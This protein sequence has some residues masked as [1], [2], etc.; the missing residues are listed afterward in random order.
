MEGAPDSAAGGAE[1]ISG[2][3]RGK[4]GGGLGTHLAKG[5]AQ[6]G[7]A[8]G[9]ISDS[10][11]DR[12]SELTKLASRAANARPL[13]HAFVRPPEGT[14][15]TK[16]DNARFWELFEKEFGLEKQPFAE[17]LHDGGQHAHRVYSL[18]KA[19]GACIRMDH[20]FA[21][22]EKIARILEIERS[23][24]LTLGAHNRSVMAALAQERPDVAE[25]MNA[26]GMADAERPRAPLTP[27]ERHQQNRTATPKAEVAAATAAAWKAS[28][29]PQAFAAALAE[30]GLRLARGKKTA[31]VL[32]AAGGTHSVARMLAMHART[33]GEP[34]PRAAEVAARLDGATLPTLAEARAAG[35]PQPPTTPPA[36]PEPQPPGNGQPS[37]PPA[38][39]SQSPQQGMAPPVGAAAPTSP[40]GDRIS[41]PSGKSGGLSPGGGGSAPAAADSG[42]AVAAHSAE[43]IAGPGPAPGPG[44]SPRELQDYREKLARYQQQRDRENAKQAA[45][46]AADADK[47]KGSAATPAAP[48]GGGHDAGDF[49]RKEENEGFV[50][51]AEAFRH[52]AATGARQARAAA[53]NHDLAAA[54]AAVTSSHEGPG[55]EVAGAGNG[56]THG[57]PGERTGGGTA[58]GPDAAAGEPGPRQTAGD[59]GRADTD[60]AG[61]CQDRGEIG[62]AGIEAARQRC[63]TA[64]IERA[65]LATDT[66][67]LKAAVAALVPDPLAGLGRQEKRAALKEWRTDLWTTFQ[68]DREVSRDE[69]RAAWSARLAAQRLAA[70]PAATILRERW[71]DLTPEQ[72]AEGWQRL[73]EARAALVETL[74][75]E[76]KERPKFGFA[77]WLEG[78]AEH[79]PKAGAV[80]AAMRAHEA[81]RETIRAALDGEAQRIAA[82]RS[83]APQ[84][85]RDELRAAQAAKDELRAEAAARQQ[86]AETARQAATEARAAVGILA[87]AGQAAGWIVGWVPAAVAEARAAEAHADRLAAA[88]IAGRPEP[89]DFREAAG[90]GRD[91]AG[92]NQR[93]YAA[94]QART[95]AGL[96]AAETRLEVVRA[97]VENRDSA[98]VRALATGGYGAAAEIV[99]RREQ[100]ERERQERQAQ[101]T[102]NLRGLPGNPARGHDAPPSG[103]RIR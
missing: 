53:A 102:A 79:D 29:S 77:E 11:Q 89:S 13:Y 85:E 61:P 19:D 76:A 34:A 36:P 50:G 5:D 69:A 55:R 42:P 72:R 100:E 23:E 84:G 75:A 44:A 52:A 87:R 6:P 90:R 24:R 78:V 56:R 93:A 65:A 40:Q 41:I 81:H 103:P 28:D 94:W 62:Q 2:A 51:I 97:A 58:A 47:K 1:V 26:A 64:R 14:A 95:G 63:A 18:V 43:T 35:A 27:E 92:R 32:D 48:A 31:V 54:L 49:H 101:R 38:Q 70:E 17:A 59:R 37:P 8:R 33:T 96:D 16:E 71:R 82:G 4:G 83:T 67:A 88:E 20:D 21:R 22:R 39:A 68:Q 74:K 9:L 99:A 45:A 98:V 25:A 60:R 86:Q 3:T 66:S 73:K 12:I 57:S 46:L 15:W 80:L 10:T 91:D 30:R 7:E